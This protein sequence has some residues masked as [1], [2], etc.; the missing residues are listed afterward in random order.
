M[1]NYKARHQFRNW[2]V[3]IFLAVIVIFW[4]NLQKNIWQKNLNEESIQPIIQNQE[5]DE[6]LNNI[7]AKLKESYQQ[8]QEAKKDFTDQ[9]KSAQTSS[10]TENATNT[11]KIRTEVIEKIKE[12]IINETSTKF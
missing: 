3:I 11:E 1:K 9:I 10:S 5:M 8:W 12:K 7:K 6:S 4:L 2:L